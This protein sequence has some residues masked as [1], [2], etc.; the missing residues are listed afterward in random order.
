MVV[1]GLAARWVEP[2]VVRAGLALSCGE[3]WCHCRGGAAEAG[4]TAL[5][6]PGRHRELLEP[7]SCFSLGNFSSLLQAVW[8]LGRD[9]SVGS[10]FTYS[11]DWGVSESSLL[12]CFSQ[13]MASPVGNSPREMYGLTFSRVVSKASL[14]SLLKYLWESG[15]TLEADR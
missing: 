3:Q 11:H 9:E 10:G 6:D 1:S 15:S 4:G 5:P 7:L 8:V 12:T 2:S 13:G 14:W